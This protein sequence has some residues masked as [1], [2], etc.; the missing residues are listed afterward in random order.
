MADQTALIVGTYERLGGTGLVPLTLCGDSM[1]AAPRVSGVPDASFG[2]WSARWQRFFFVVEQESGRLVTCGA[3]LGPVGAG[4]AS[5]GAAPCHLAL[6]REER[7][8]AVANYESGSVALF[9][10]DAGALPPSPAAM[11]QLAGHGADPERQG[12]PHAH[13]VGFGGDGQWLYVVDLGTDAVLRLPV[14]P[15]AATLGEPE[16]A[17]A[18]PAGSGPRH[19]AFHPAGPR[20]YLVS[21]LASTLTVLDVDPRGTLTPVQTRSTLPEGASDSLGGAIVINAAADRLYVTNRGH[22][23]IAAFAVHPDGV[24]LIQT[25]SSGGASPRFLLLLEE[26]RRLLVANEEGGTVCQFGIDVD[27]RLDRAGEPVEIPGAVFLARRPG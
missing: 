3:D 26:E 7:F 8:L 18:A 22:D 19:L 21:E 16:I 5:G 15:D 17:Y 2:R 11:H 12:G 4:A 6:D 27:G 14:D 24:T 25:V 13:W 20:A 1:T 9:R 10:I 23:S